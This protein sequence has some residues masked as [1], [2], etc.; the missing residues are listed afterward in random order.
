MPD[1]APAPM[2][3]PGSP[4]LRLFRAM[5]RHHLAQ[6]HLICAQPGRQVLQQGLQG[7]VLGLPIGCVGRVGRMRQQL[8]RR[9]TQLGKQQVAAQGQGA[10]WS[11]QRRSSPTGPA[12]VTWARCSASSRCSRA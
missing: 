10:T 8:R 5:V 1:E 2:G 3:R 4:A 12:S 9:R 7:L 6:A 11:A